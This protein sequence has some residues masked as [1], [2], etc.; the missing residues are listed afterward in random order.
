MTTKNKHLSLENRQLIEELLNE[1]KSFKE[2]GRA[3]CKDCTTISKEIKKNYQTIY[4]SKFNGRNTCIL[5]MECEHSN[6]CNAKCDKYQPDI[7]EKT[8]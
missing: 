3:T 6:Y 2:I 5:K 8:I 1:G 4:P 7:C